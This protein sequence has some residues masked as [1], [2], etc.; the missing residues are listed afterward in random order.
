[1]ALVAALPEQAN[2]LDRFLETGLANLRLGPAVADDVLVEVLAGPHAQEEPSGHE[3][4]GGGGG[5]SN[6]GGVDAHGR[7]GDRGADREAL[8]GMGDGAEHGPHEGAL[9]LPVS[10]G[11]VMVGDEGEAEAGILRHLRVAD[12]ID[13]RLF[14]AR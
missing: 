5:L 2:H 9:T 6:D 4:R 1:M 11:M 3:R 12:E 7:A 13:S 8:G 10:P 14:L